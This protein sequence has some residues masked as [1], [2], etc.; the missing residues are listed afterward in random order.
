MG[1]P[2]G[3]SS[4]SV[5]DVAD[6]YRRYGEFVFRTLSRLGVPS[7]A[8]DDATQDVFVILHRRRASYQQGAPIRAWLFGISRHVARKHRGKARAIEHGADGTGP[9]HAC[10]SFLSDNV[11]V[12]EAAAF[13]EKFLASLDESKRDVFVLAEIESIPVVEVA[14]MLGIKLN[15][16][17]SRLRLARKRFATALLRRHTREQRCLVSPHGTSDG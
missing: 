1:R 9:G 3:T 14:G 10:D 15:T 12:G 16:V 11:A 17:Y 7:Q 2:P 6:C 8:L 13:V 4:P 5:L